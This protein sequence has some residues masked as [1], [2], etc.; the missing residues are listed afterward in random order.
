MASLL[1]RCFCECCSRD[2][3][4]SAKGGV[5]FESTMQ[6]FLCNPFPQLV[7]ATVGQGTA[8]FF[9]CDFE[10]RPRSIIHLFHEKFLLLSLK[11]AL[12]MF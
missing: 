9:Q 1:G 12:L 2:I 4:Q 6:Q 7:I 5:A 8:S 3:R 11:E 10:V